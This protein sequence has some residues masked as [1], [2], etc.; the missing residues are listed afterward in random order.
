VKFLFAIIGLYL[1]AITDQWPGAIFGFFIG[2]LA[3]T[4][5]QYRKRILDLEDRVRRIQ[6]KLGV[7][8]EVV[9][10]HPAAEEEEEDITLVPPDDTGGRG[11]TT[12][13]QPA[14]PEAETPPQEPAEETPAEREPVQSSLAGLA[15]EDDPVT[16]WIK[17]FF[18]SGNVVVKVG[19]IILFFG[20]AFL[21]KY[22]AEKGIFP[23]ELRLAAV[24]AGGI[25]LL[26][27]GWRLRHKK[28]NYALVLQGGAVGILYLTVFAAARHYDVLPLGFAFFVMFAL[29]V[30]SCALAVIQDSRSLA[31]FATAGGFLAPVLVSTGSGNHVALFS[32]Y[33]LLNVGILGIAWFKAWRT[34]NWVGF[35]FTFVIASLWGYEH[36]RPQHFNT[37]E[38]FLILFFLFYVAIAILFAHR[39]PPHLKGVVD[40]TLVFGTPLVGFALQS[41]LIEDYP[42]GEAYSALAMAALYAILARVFFDKKIEGMR[43]LTESFLALAVIFVSLAVPLA[44]DGRWTAA[45]W[46]VEGAGILWIGIRQNR[47][48]ARLFGMLLQVGAAIAFLAVVDHPHADLP[49]FNSAYIGSVLISIAGLFTG[50]QYYRQ[51]L[52]LR[53]AERELHLLFLIWG[54]LWWFGAG[55]MEIEYHVSITYETNAILFFVAVS[56]LV[57]TFI[58]YCVYWLTAEKISLFLL[59]VI[60]AIGLMSYADTP[61]INPFVNLGWISWITAFAVQYLFLFRSEKA[62]DKPILEF[63][64]A[65]TLWLYVFMGT[66][67][68]AQ[69][70][71][72]Y[73]SGMQNWNN[74]L[75]GAIPAIAVFKL[76]YLRDRLHWP[77]Q[78][79]PVQYLAIG[80]FPIAVY[81]AGWTVIMCLET[82]NPAPLPYIPVVNPQDIAQLFAM[83]VLFDWLGHWKQGRIPA[84]PNVDPD[85][86]MK[87]LGVIAFVWLN[88][89]VAH[90]VHFYFDVPY[91]AWSLFRSE[92][93]QTSITI[94]WTLTAFALMGFATKNGLRNLWYTGAGLLAAVVIKLFLIDLDDTGTVARIVSFLSVGGLMLLIGYVTPLPPKPVK[95]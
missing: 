60:T 36:Y 16:A 93:F 29:V 55:L 83:V 51:R 13:T 61:Y 86:L 69:A 95:R 37:T 43:L 41:Q 8:A 59:P 22:V 66:W 5:I 9:E 40:G 26:I 39:Q 94:L 1:G 47:L 10:A 33:A 48:L 81:L 90:V 25:A 27:T 75:W 56:L 32:Y 15:R 64:H 21:V 87:I 24:A 42:F 34:L 92:I 67:I 77:V 71:T 52:Q 18:T 23:I 53:D 49:V 44:L 17:S 20:V 6:D 74:V 46:S 7:E 79:Y 62:W 3:G 11:W 4:L 82:G 12:G 50:L 30:F 14:E 85:V 73:V 35:V 2:I 72:H 68:I 45:A 91:R 19:I 28:A 76:I 54:S 84:L 78:R 58:A 65:W 63:W 57:M 38:P 70:L 88:S 80:I 89:L 31:T